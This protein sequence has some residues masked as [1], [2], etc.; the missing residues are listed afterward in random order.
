MILKRAD[1]AVNT[2]QLVVQ[3]LR[4]GP[5]KDIYA[6]GTVNQV[7]TTR[8]GVV[9]DYMKSKPTLRSLKT[10]WVLLGSL[11]KR[12]V[13]D[14]KTTTLS[15]DDLVLTLTAM[16][17]YPLHYRDLVRGSILTLYGLVLNLT[18]NHLWS[19]EVVYPTELRVLDN[20]YSGTLILRKLELGKSCRSSNSVLS[21][22]RDLCHYCFTCFL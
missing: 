2:D 19:V 21:F 4:E 11:A 12:A 9:L 15:S 1:N 6:V 16:S 5:N 17:T 3:E 10:A 8:L 20:C 22:K 18:I 13:L 14:I 7:I